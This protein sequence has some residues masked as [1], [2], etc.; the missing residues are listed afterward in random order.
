MWH[1]LRAD[2]GA[3]LA[4]G[5]RE[6]IT[7]DQMHEASLSGEIEQLLNWFEVKPGETYMVDAGTV[8]ALG[9]GLAL[10][11]IQQFSDIT[12]RL[13][14]YGRP[15]PLHLDKAMA[16]SNTGSHPG[17]RPPVTCSNGWTLIGESQYFRTETRSLEDKYDYRT[18]VGGPELLAILEGSGQIANEPFNAGEVWIMPA[19]ADPGVVQ[20]SRRTKILRTFA[21]PR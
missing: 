5:F 13:Y 16:V 15:R 19:G 11:E 20:P 7:P 3:R 1:I 12:Y 17:A 4:L 2:P 6:P 8:H 9:A 10:V 14:D 21:P 18:E